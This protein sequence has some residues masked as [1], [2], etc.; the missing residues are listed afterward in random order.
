MMHVHTEDQSYQWKNRDKREPS[1]PA[2]SSETERE[3]DR[4]TESKTESETES[5]TDSVTESETDRETGKG[6][7]GRERD[8]YGVNVGSASSQQA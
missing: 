2:T 4:E 8:Y 7:G 6:V 3:G 1:T 5:E